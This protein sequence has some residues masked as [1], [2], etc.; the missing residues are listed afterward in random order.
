M[1]LEKKVIL[2]EDG[3]YLVYYHFPETATAEQSA[4][5]AAVTPSP[6]ATATEHGADANPPDAAPPTEGSRTGV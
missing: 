2:K 5:F 3:R 6:E 4:V 1:R